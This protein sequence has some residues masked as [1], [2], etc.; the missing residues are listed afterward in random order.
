V[1]TVGRFSTKVCQPTT[2]S[3]QSQLQKA[4]LVFFSEL[5]MRVDLTVKHRDVVCSGGRTLSLNDDL[6]ARTVCRFMN[7]L[8]GSVLRHRHQRPRP[9]LSAMIWEERGPVTRRRHL[10][11]LIECPAMCD[12]HAFVDAVRKAWGAQ[13]FAHREM[14]IEAIQSPTGSAIY[15]MKAGS[16]ASAMYL[17]KTPNSAAWWRLAGPAVRPSPVRER[18]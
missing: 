15:N 17:S 8:S 7:R 6:L 10:H 1:M 3:M 16:M 12:R 14:H 13:P 4:W 2:T 9:H 11:A 5:N 18:S